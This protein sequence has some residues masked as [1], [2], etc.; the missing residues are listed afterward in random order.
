[1]M[2]KHRADDMERARPGNVEFKFLYPVLINH[3][4]SEETASSFLRNFVCKHLPFV[5]L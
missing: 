2:C 5:A 3:A 1:M 4:V